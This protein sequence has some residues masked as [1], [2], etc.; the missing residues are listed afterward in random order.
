[1]ASVLVWN[2]LLEERC[3]TGLHFVDVW[4]PLQECGTLQCELG[5]HHQQSGE[6]VPCEGF[7]AFADDVF[8]LGSLIPEGSGQHQGNRVGLLRDDNLSRAKSTGF[9]AFVDDL[10]T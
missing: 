1:M 4:R 10:L 9:R 6:L 3:P 5:S 2:N 8:L 7:S